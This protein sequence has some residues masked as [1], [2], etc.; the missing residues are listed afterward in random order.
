MFNAGEV[1]N[2]RISGIK[3]RQTQH[4][5]RGQLRAL[6]FAKGLN[7]LRTE[8]GIADNDTGIRINGGNAETDGA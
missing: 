8:V 1:L 2:V 6:C 3:S 7:Y 4:I 5:A